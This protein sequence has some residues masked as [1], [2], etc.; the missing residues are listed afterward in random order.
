[1]DKM[2]DARDYLKDIFLEMDFNVQF[3]KCKKHDAVFAQKIIDKNLPTLLIYGHYDVQPPDP[4]NEWH[5]D[6]FDPA[7]KNN[8]IYARGAV[9]NKGQVMAHIMAAK[10]LIEENKTL[11]CNLKFIIEGEE[12]IGSVSVFQLAQ[13]YAKTL[14]D[15]DYIIVSDGEMREK[16]QP[17][18]EISLR[19]LLYTEITIQASKQDLHSGIFG[20]VAENPANFL[21]FLIS[22]LKN[23]N[24][25]ILI[26][27]FY[28]DVIHPS[29]EEL[30][31]YGI[32]K[33]SEQEIMHEGKLFDIGG[34]EKE[35]SLN[36]RRWSRPTLDVNGITS[37]Y[38]KEGSKTII[39][40]KASSKISMR[41]VP[42]QDP[43]K[44]FAE[45]EKYLKSLTP[46]SL[47]LSVTKHSTALPYKAPTH[48]PIFNIAKKSLKKAFGKEPL[49]V[50]VGGTIGFIPALSKALNVPVVMM[51]FGTP[52]GNMHA[53]NEF[54][55]LKNYFQGIEA[56][57]DFYIN[58]TDLSS[59]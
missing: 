42:N 11:P 26:P 50:G 35:F 2:K 30:Q 43:D 20:G 17:V 39:P 55:P 36:E 54:L 25:K 51:G 27:H 14:F 48:H 18:I 47:K 38:Q 22:K 56:M 57:K 31:D 53:P 41:L 58:S 28:T 32:A 52:T 4:L 24:H 16:N 29:P 7:I 46:N 3:L 13:K 33:T 9:D 34:G 21:S 44:I 23:E 45:F 8:N 59:P 37:G 49:F 15:C 6:P 19:G 1:M 40:A 12:E 10:T 5:T